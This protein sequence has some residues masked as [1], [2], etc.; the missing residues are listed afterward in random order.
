M[1]MIGFSWVKKSAVPANI[2]TSWEVFTLSFAVTEFMMN[3][4]NKYI[5]C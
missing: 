3:V 4:D 5:V 2:K 1:V